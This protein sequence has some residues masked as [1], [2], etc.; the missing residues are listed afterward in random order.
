MELARVHEDLGEFHKAIG[1]YEQL[2]GMK[3]SPL[4]LNTESQVRLFIAKNYERLGEFDFALSF[5]TPLLSL[6]ENTRNK[7]L[8]LATLYNIGSIHQ[9]SVIS[10]TL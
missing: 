4:D 6:A 7:H 10:T 1:Y 3:Q 5:Y 9:C 8:E 2:L